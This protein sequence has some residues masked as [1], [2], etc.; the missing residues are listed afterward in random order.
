MTE[1][2]DRLCV[3]ADPYLRTDDVRALER[4]VERT[5]IS[6]PLVVVN[7]P[8]DPSID[9]EVEAN[10][11]NERFGL[12]T[13][14]VLFTLLKTHRAWTLVFAEKKLAAEFGSTAASSGRVHVEDVSCLADAEV[15]YVTP[16]TEGNWNELPRDAVELVRERSDV[17]VRFGF[18]LLRGDVLDAPEFGVLSFH[19]AD[20]RTYRGLGA[21][22]AWIDGR[23]TMGVTLQRLNEDIDGGEI[24][25]YDET[26]VSECATLWEA[27][28][29]LYDLKADLLAQGIENLRD[30]S[31]E[32]TIPETLGPYNS[33]DKRRSLRFAGRTLHKNLTG[34]LRASRRKP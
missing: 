14:R 21:P 18:G 19:Q 25:A 27:Y 34:R 1:S 4:A 20:I 11:V 13:L 31:F 3:L 8:E 22:Q 2:P 17:A 15:L 23:E 7:D 26:D 9:P 10:A 12:G 33:V 24:V 29:R 28:D 16:R 6:I 30:P 32:P 5:G